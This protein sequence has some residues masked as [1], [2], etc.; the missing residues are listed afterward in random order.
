VSID[1]APVL[2]LEASQITEKWGS[3]TSPTFAVT[4]GA[5]TLAFTIGAGEGMDLIDNVTIKYCK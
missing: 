1:G 5:H 2:T 3:Y 4:S